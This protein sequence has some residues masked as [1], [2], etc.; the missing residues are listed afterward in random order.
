MEEFIYN[1]TEETLEE[2][3]VNP[4]E[5]EDTGNNE[6][7]E[8]QIPNGDDI[9]PWEQEQQLLDDVWKADRNGDGIVDAARISTD[10]D[11]DGIVD[12]EGYY[13]DDNFDGKTD[14]VLEY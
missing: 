8:T 7:G 12:F 3:L 11:G 5:D 4:N 1:E 13:Y 14:M 9:N 2:L 6:E 10:T